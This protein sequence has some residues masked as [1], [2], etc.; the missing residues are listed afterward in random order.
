MKKHFTLIELI[1]VV[2]TFSILVFIV[3]LNIK[4]FE[5]DSL[6]VVAEAN[7]TNLQHS[8]DH[9]SLKNNGNYPI[10]GL[11][12]GS[13]ILDFAKLENEYIREN[14][15]TFPSN[16]WVDEWGRVWASSI[17]TPQN[18]L[19]E[20]GVISWRGVSNASKYRVYILERDVLT[21]DVSTKH[22][23]LVKG[24]PPSN[25]AHVSVRL[26]TEKTGD[27]YVSAIDQHGLETLPVKARTSSDTTNVENRPPVAKIT[28]NHPEEIQVGQDVSWSYSP[29]SDPDGDELVEV[30]WEG[31]V[32]SFE[33]IGTYL[34]KLRVKDSKGL[35]SEW[36]SLEVNVNNGLEGEGTALSPYLIRNEDELN[37]VRH[38]PRAHYLLVN[39]FTVTKYQQ[40]DGWDPIGTNKNPFIGTF[41]GNSKTISNLYIN[42]LGQN[43]VGLFGYIQGGYISNLTLNNVNVKGNMHVGGLVGNISGGRIERS[44][45]TGSV[46]GVSHSIGGL[47][48]STGSTTLVSN[49]SS[50]SV[51]EST[52]TPQTN[53]SS[54]VGGLIGYHRGTVSKSYA[55][56]S[57]KGNNRSVGGLVGINSGL[58]DKSF[59]FGPVSG[60]HGTGGLVG[61][62]SGTITDSYSLGKYTISGGAGGGLVGWASGRI[63]R[64]YSIGKGTLSGSNSYSGGSIGYAYNL[65]LSNV[66]W[67]SQSSETN[68]GI[69]GTSGYISSYPIGRTS[70][71][72]R[73][74]AYFAFDFNNIWSIT[75][76]MDFPR[77]RL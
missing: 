27:Y 53:M 36:E 41:N 45:T 29:S 32:S 7:I 37:R 73:M 31:N 23:L 15:S 4:D 51:V 65:T 74:K 20:K 42:R 12:E 21:G 60:G 11:E 9:Y 71:Q 72:M 56:G 68:I 19:V 13:R 57:A 62:L 17:E 67:D 8:V 14:K 54:Y 76:N 1:T 18:T 66:Y 5:S 25:E 43:D 34:V 38:D 39:S 35:W 58:V 26:T 30:E 70:S 59:S 69:V 47:I 55:T 48:G 10:V 33:S 24:V 77:I 63:E 3:N 2:A 46:M 52:S 16:F 40:G 28:H 64:S 44:R 50:S 61:T 6:K 22:L 49:S 75:E